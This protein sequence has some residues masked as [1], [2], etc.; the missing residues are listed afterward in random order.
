MLD[1][2]THLA[3]DLAAS[4]RLDGVVVETDD[5]VLDG[6]RVGP[7]ALFAPQELEQWLDEHG[8]A[9][10][11][12]SPP[13]PFYRQHLTAAAAR[14]WVRALND[15][16]LVALEG[17]SRLVPMAYLPL[18]HPQVALAEL[19]RLRSDPRWGGITA[20]AGGGSDPLDSNALEPVWGLLAALGWPVLLHP[21]HSPDPRLEPYYLSNLL[22]NPV[23][24]G[25]AAAQLLFGDVL[26]R[27]PGLRVLLVHCGGVV[28]AVLGRWERGITTARPGVR[29]L[30]RPFREAARGFWVDSLG[31]EPALLDLAVQTFGADRVV[32]GSDWPFPMGVDDPVASVAHRGSEFVRTVGRDNVRALVG[33]LPAWQELVALESPVT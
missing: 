5:V 4:G 15:G 25:V 6:K 32:I 27:H 30:S 28:P 18:E 11:A 16:I 3:P 13:P 7:A 20:A 10:A 31:H 29:N 21:G 23:E 22:G 14:G 1:L 26:G 2:H 8:L 19:E 12:V 17:R 24:T 33:D 9:G